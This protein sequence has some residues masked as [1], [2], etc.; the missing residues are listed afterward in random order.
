MD[1]IPVETLTFILKLSILDY[2]SSHIYPTGRPP[3]VLHVC[4]KWKEVATNTPGC[5]TSLMFNIDARSKCAYGQRNIHLRK[6]EGKA[7]QDVMKNYFRWAKNVPIALSLSYTIPSQE[8]SQNFQRKLA[9]WLIK[10]IPKL[11]SFSQLQDRYY[12]PGTGGRM[13]D[14]WTQFPSN[15]VAHLTQLHVDWIWKRDHTLILYSRRRIYWL[16]FFERGPGF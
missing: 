2:F 7:T 4:R 15:C 13:T 3:V 8:A 5:W 14:I 9:P 1:T 10:N 16:P 6:T 11:R 12:C